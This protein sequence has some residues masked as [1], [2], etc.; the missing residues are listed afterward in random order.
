MIINI[1]T[2]YIMSLY[3]CDFDTAA[4][5][6]AELDDKQDKFLNRIDDAIVNMSDELEIVFEP[7]EDTGLD[8]DK[9]IKLVVDNDAE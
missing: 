2:D 9:A 8:F 3:D 4:I 5:I 1:D 7:E 6:L